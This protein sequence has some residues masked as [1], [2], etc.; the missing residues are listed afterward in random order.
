MYSRSYS[1]SFV[2]L[3]KAVLDKEGV[4]F[5]EILIDQDREALDRVV[6]WTG[7]RAVPTLV[8]ANLGEVLPYE[9]PE[10]LPK[11]HSPRGVNR[12]S[13]IT[14]PDRTQLR[15]WLKNNGFVSR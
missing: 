9:S 12:G 3:A 15:Q 2:T 14:E 8:A 6:E 7:F 1:C 5:H 10:P 4:P 11:G 13:M